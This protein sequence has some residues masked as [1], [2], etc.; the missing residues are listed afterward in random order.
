MTSQVQQSP[1]LIFGSGRSGTTWL[2]ETVNCDRTY[3]FFFEP[4]NNRKIDWLKHFIF[5]SQY[6]R[7]SCTDP[8]YVDPIRKV[9]AGT[10]THPWVIRR[11]GKH[12]RAKTNHILIKDI[13]IHFLV[14]WIKRHYPDSPMIFILRHPCAVATSRIQLNW[15]DCLD[16]LLGQDELVNDYLAPLAA[17]LRSLNDPFERNIAIWAIE[18]YVPLRQFS[19]GEVHILHYEHL[20]CQFQSEIEQVFT[21]LGR[22]VPMGIEK[23]AQRPSALVSHNSAI[24]KGKDKL[25]NWMNFCTTAQTDRAIEILSWFGLDRLYGKGFLPLM[26]G[27]QWMS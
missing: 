23:M 12:D 19:A 16:A 22:N 2:A 7:S 4:F 11:H 6:L 1:I 24:L 25:S 18:N 21:Y 26:H 15:D 5:H 3:R 14:N 27:F 10:V 20:C 17:P 9:L 13:R 8:S